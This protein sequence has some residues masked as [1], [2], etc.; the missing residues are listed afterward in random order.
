MSSEDICQTPIDLYRVSRDLYTA[1]MLDASFVRRNQLTRSLVGLIPAERLKYKHVFS[2]QN[3]PVEL[4][5]LHG[6]HES[7][8]WFAVCFTHSTAI[9]VSSIRTAQKYFISAPESWCPWCKRFLSSEGLN[10]YG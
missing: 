3:F 5:I 9:R 6:G 10:L 7:M 8:P 4:V 1:D 2:H